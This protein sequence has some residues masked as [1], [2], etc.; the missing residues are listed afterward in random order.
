MNNRTGQH[1]I[2]SPFVTLL[3]VYDRCSGKGCKEI[4]ITLL[5]IVYIN[6][7]GYF[8]DSCSED[9]LHLGLAVEVGNAVV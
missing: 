5:K 3:K 9:L 4:G 7:T 6:K 2:L 1:Y 8:C